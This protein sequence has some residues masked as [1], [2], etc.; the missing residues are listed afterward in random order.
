MHNE[1][2]AFRIKFQTSTTT[3]SFAE[4]SAEAGTSLES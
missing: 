4:A 2:N 1:E 3:C